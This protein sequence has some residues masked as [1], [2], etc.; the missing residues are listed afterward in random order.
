MMRG[1]HSPEH[2]AR[3]VSIGVLVAMTPTVGVQM[4]IVA[5]LWFAV[6]AAFPV[7]DFNLIAALAWTWVT[8]IFTVPPVYYLFYLTGR[9]MMGVGGPGHGFDSF[10]AILEETLSADAGWFE[11]LWIY[12]LG[13][14]R[15]F[16]VPMFVG[17]LPWAL[18][19]AWLGYRWSLGLIVRLRAARD[20]KRRN[21]VRSS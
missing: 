17:C 18:L 15:R 4:P 16:G 8:N 6:R 10:S 7:W 14:F 12:T 13:L 1:R 20:R 5:L 2:A 11:T 19:S 21:R 9:L 3:G